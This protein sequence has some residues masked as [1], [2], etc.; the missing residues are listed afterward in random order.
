MALESEEADPKLCEVGEIL[1][2]PKR[3]ALHRGSRYVVG[4][5]VDL[6]ERVCLGERWCWVL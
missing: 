1:F 2:R 6:K 4:E 3:L 5:K